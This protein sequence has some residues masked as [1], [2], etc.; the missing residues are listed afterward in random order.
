MKAL[1]SVGM[2]V[3]KPLDWNRH[4]VAMEWIQ[5]TLLDNVR[6]EERPEASSDSDNDSDESDLE[7]LEGKP[8]V[9]N[10]LLILIANVSY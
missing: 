4:C 1:T 10:I 2:P 8:K 7:E 6:S 5:G 9:I 3:P